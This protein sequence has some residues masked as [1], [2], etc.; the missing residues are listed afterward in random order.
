MRPLF[1]PWSNTVIRLVLIVLQ[2]GAAGGLLLLLLYK[3]TPLAT[4]Q[5][6]PVT[7]PI[8]FDHRHHVADDGIDCRYC[9]NTVE[10]S[11]SA[12]YPATSVCM[13]CHAQ[14]WN[15]SP[16]LDLV[17]KAYF[18]G[19]PIVWKKVHQLPDFV[20]FNH[21]IHVAKGVGCVTCHGRVDQMP[22]IRQGPTMQMG[23]CLEC[24]RNPS[25]NLR[26]KEFMTTMI[27]TAEGREKYGW[28]V[29]PGVGSDSGANTA[30]NPQNMS[31]VHSRTSCTTCHR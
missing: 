27:D 19:Q 8:E 17:R 30:Q 5:H 2:G 23:W 29:I 16:Y 4:L 28:P 3:R 21:S 18:S 7:Q 22:E 11:S 15:Q 31:D 9:H 6:E 1:P 20:F 13:N 12:G 26:P 14:I 25:P 10:T 24:H